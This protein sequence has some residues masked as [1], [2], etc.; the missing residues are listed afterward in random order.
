MVCHPH[1]LYG[2]DMHHAVVAAVATALQEAGLAT[3][4]FDFR[5]T[6]DSDGVHSG[7]DGEVDDARAAVDTLLSQPGLQH[8]AIAGY[9]F[10]AWIAMRLAGSDPRLRA[11]VAVAPPLAMVDTSSVGPITAPGLVLVGERDAYCPAERLKTFTN[12]RS[13]CRS[14]VLAAT[15]HFLFGR[16]REAAR[17]VAGFLAGVL[18]ARDIRD[19]R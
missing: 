4:R 7:G 10:G 14:E 6:G 18:A 9:S 2:G 1:P 15:D 13:G 19:E 17:A 8:A 3:L 12:G 5:G 16:E 11:V